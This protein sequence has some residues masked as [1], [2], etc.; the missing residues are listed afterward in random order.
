MSHKVKKYRKILLEPLANFNVLMKE[1]ET[2]YLTEQG[3]CQTSRNEF[4]SLNNS[5]N[6]ISKTHL[7]SPLSI[8]RKEYISHRL[9][10]SSY[11][12]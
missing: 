3:K 12:F 10:N 9:Y 5:N 8:K 4:N 1:A 11:D 7:K 6:S 2:L